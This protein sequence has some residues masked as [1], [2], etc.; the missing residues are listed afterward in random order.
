VWKMPAESAKRVGHPAPFPIELPRRLIELLTYKDDVVLDPF[1]G[2][3]STAVAA[4]RT[5]RHYVGYDLDPAYAK[6]S[7]DRITA[8]VESLSG[9][10]SKPRSSAKP[11]SSEVIATKRMS[12]PHV[13]RAAKDSPGTT[14]KPAVEVAPKTA[15][16]PT[17]K[18]LSMPVK[19]APRKTVA[20]TP[21]KA[22]RA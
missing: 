14:L 9:A 5:G 22:A 15:A 4:V 8:E 2:A 10:T 21:K 18:S 7:Q 16:K 13:K 3:G 12:A 1:M 11:E 19:G 20:A 6:L 17:L